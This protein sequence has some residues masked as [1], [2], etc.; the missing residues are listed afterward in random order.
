MGRM[1]TELLKPEH[2]QAGF[3]VEDDED[4]VYLKQGDKTV[5]VWNARQVTGDMIRAEA[6]RLMAKAGR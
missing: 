5:A 4:F 1:L 6:D 2:V 3:C